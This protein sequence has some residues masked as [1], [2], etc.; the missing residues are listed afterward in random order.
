MESQMAQLLADNRSLRE[1][2]SRSHQYL[3]QLLR[4][5]DEDHA[6][7]IAIETRNAMSGPAIPGPSR[8]VSDRPR[9]LK[10]RRIVENSEEEEEGEKEEEKIVEEEKDGEGEEEVE[11]EEE[12]GEAPVPKK[13]K[14]VASEKGKE[15]EIVVVD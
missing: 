2:T 14:T 12:E 4:R 13:A 7:L 10:R 3:R 6:Q 5:Q 11:E 15:K 8:S 9:S 1:A